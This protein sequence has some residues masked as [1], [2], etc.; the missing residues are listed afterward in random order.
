[1]KQPAKLIPYLHAVS[2]CNEADK[3]WRIFPVLIQAQL[4]LQ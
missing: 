1:V 2:D 3:V 4:K